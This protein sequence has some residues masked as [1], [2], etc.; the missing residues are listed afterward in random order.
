MPLA[1]E[2]AEHDR[3]DEGKS[4]ICRYN[5]Q[6]ACESHGKLPFFHAAVRIE[7]LKIANRLLAKKSA[8]LS[9]RRNTRARRG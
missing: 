7:N 8:P 2:H 3:A 6:S 1:S 9:V 5:A 4:D